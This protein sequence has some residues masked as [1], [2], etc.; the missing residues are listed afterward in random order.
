MLAVTGC[1][2]A[3]MAQ[4][5][6]NA[7]LFA[8][9]NFQAGGLTIS[10]GNGITIA[11]NRFGNDTILK[12]EQ[13]TYGASVL[14]NYFE[15]GPASLQPPVPKQTAILGNRGLQNSPDAQF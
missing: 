10:E 12:F 9:C 11:G 6:C 2:L 1:S 13:G 3:G 15:D 4:M 7:A 8:G 5:T 14:G